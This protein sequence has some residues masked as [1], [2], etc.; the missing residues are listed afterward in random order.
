MF[1]NSRIT[2]KQENFRFYRLFYITEVSFSRYFKREVSL[3]F[4]MNRTFP[5]FTSVSSNN[6]S[7]NL[8]YRRKVNRGLKA[9][10]FSLR[11]MIQ[12]CY[13]CKFNLIVYD[14][15]LGQSPG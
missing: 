6:S 12:G 4:G 8:F 3:Y 1:R 11:I 2:A 7:S 10:W 14:A 5:H 9:I 15:Y 13:Y